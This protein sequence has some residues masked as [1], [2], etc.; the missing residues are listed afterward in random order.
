MARL[1]IVHSRTAQGNW[2][3]VGVV[4]GTPARL[5]FQFLPGQ[6]GW[7]RWAEQ[8]MTSASPPFKDGTGV[9]PERGTWEDWIPWAVDAFTNGH[10]A[11]L[12]L[13]TEPEPLLEG[14]YRKYVLGV[15]PEAPSPVI[16]EPG[17]IPELGGFE[18]V[19][20]A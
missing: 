15:A 16:R 19:R 7:Q 18:K 8:A 10:D 6:T 12:T 11:W 13:I 20:P 1:A 4:L 17:D 9:N 2:R 3:P 5:D 14:N